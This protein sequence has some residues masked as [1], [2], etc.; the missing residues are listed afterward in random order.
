MVYLAFSVPECSRRTFLPI[1]SREVFEME[2]VISNKPRWP[3][4]PMTVGGPRGSAV[5]H[6]GHGP[7]SV[8][9]HGDIGLVV[10]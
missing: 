6:T 9:P 3:G 4:S 1:S 7:A 2:S 8:S 10:P 5:V